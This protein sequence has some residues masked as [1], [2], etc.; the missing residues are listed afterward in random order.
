MKKNREYEQMGVIIHI[1]MEMSQGHSLCTFMSN[2]QKLLFFSFF[3]YKIGE[4]EDGGTCP[5]GEEGVGTSGRGRWYG[6]GIGG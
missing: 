1:Y 4:Q 2:K 5:V 3:C 6:K